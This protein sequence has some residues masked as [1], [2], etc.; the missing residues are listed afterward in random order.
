MVPRIL[1]QGL[2]VMALVSAILVLGAAVG[3][4]R[5][6]PGQEPIRSTQRSRVS[7]DRELAAIARDIDRASVGET[8]VAGSLAAEFG[9]SEES[10]LLE[11]RGLGASWGD[12]TIAHTLAASDKLGMTAAQVLQLHDRGMGWGQVAA[13]LR[14]SLDDAIRAVRD[15]SR[16][17]REQVKADGK[18][19]PIRGDGL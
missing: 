5:G 16:V 9:G 8:R 7:A 10:M 3:Q 13:G 18:A 15:E 12:L 6:G 4:T 1:A 2:G 17:A 19:T 11:K 14:F